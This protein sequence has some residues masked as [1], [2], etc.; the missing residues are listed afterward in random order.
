M[1]E[2]LRTNQDAIKDGSGKYVVSLHWQAAGKATQG[3][4]RI[5]G[6]QDEEVICGSAVDA[7]SNFVFFLISND[8]HVISL[9]CGESK[10]GEIGVVLGEG[11]GGSVI[12][13]LV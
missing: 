6:E 1:Q 4:C 2:A 3:Q 10:G 8:L 13:H 5:F 7:V 9:E 12:E 11:E